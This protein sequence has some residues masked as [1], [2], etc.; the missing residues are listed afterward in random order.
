M[1][2]TVDAI[3]CVEESDEVGADDVYLVVFQG[4]TVLPFASTL[5]SIG[6]GRTWQD[7]DTGET[8]SADV[9]VAPTNA[10]AV[11]AVMMIEKDDGK[12]IQGA[13]VDAFRTAT[14][15]VWR[16]LM[17]GILASGRPTNAE[18]AKAAGFA[19]IRTT[20]NGL[21]AVY[22]EFPK[23]NDDVLD[24]KRVTITAAGQSQTIRF[25][26]GPEDATYDVTFKQTATP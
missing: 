3:K 26:S 17:L 12:D 6:P 7:F 16:S 15:L 8:H 2:L 24:I 5:S 1:S 4:R 20:L 14:D 10:D 9:R 25:R 23:G 21:T 11:Y 19:S 18:P 13:V 22:T